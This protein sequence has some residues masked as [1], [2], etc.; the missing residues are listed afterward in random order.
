MAPRGP[1]ITFG[2]YDRP[3]ESGQPNPV[4]NTWTETID[5]PWVDDP[6]YDLFWTCAASG[7]SRLMLDSIL[8]P[9]ADSTTNVSAGT[10]W[11]YDAGTVY[12]YSNPCGVGPV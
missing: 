11:Y 6:T 3:G 12:L 10:P 8:Q 7:A 5:S 1:P 4:W 2:A 9:M